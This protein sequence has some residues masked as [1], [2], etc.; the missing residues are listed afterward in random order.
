ML[1][2]LILLLLTGLLAP[3]YADEK[4]DAQKQLQAARSDVAELKKLLEKLQLEKSGVQQD[5]QKTETEMGQL[6]KQVKSLQ[7][8]LHESEEELQRLDQQ[9]KNSRARA[10]NSSA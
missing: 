4:A 3:A 6:E 2:A 5:L 7:G 10:L 8:E 1:R 9:K